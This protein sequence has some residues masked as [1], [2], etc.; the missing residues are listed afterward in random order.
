MTRQ[1]PSS[2]QTAE[3]VTDGGNVSYAD[4]SPF[5]RLLKNASRVKMLDALLRRPATEFSASQLSELAG[6]SE[7]AI[8]RNKSTLVDLGIVTATKRGGTTYYSINRD[9]DVVSVLA[10]FH[11]NL[12]TYYE[13]ILTNTESLDEEMLDWVQWAIEANHSEEEEQQEEDINSDDDEEAVR[14]AIVA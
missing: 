13:E 11:I 9:N 14:E 10:E 8:S 7:S 2:K 12:L 1:P 4:H 3:P 6:I 5:V